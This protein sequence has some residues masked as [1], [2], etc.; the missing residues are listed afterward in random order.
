MNIG[1]VRAVSVSGMH[2]DTVT[3]QGFISSGLPYFT[4]VGLPDS[5]LV[6]AR[7]RV[8]A[9]CKAIHFSWP[10]S[11]ITVNLSPASL[12]K[13]GAGFDLSI[14]TCIFSALHCINSSLID[15]TVVMG[16]LALDGSVLPIPAILP[17]MLHARAQGFERVII[18]AANVEEASII[19]DIEIVGVHHLYE[20]LRLLGGPSEL[21]HH[22]EESASVS[23]PSAS[24]PSSENAR[25]SQT[26]SPV[27]SAELSTSESMNPFDSISLSHHDL[28]QDF[29]EIIGHADAKWAMEIAAAGGHHVL[30]QGS[31]G[32]GK[33]ML[34]H[35]LPSI[36]PDLTHDESIELACIR[37]AQG[38]PVELPLSKSVP[39]IDIHHNATLP[40]LVGGIIGGH[41]RPGAVTLAHH[42]I[43]FMDEAPEFSRSVLQALRVPLETHSITISRT[44]GLVT[45][46][47]DFQLILAQNPCPC[48]KLWGE[49]GECV[50][51]PQ[52]LRRYRQRISAPILDRI[53]MKVPLSA[54]TALKSSSSS[55][56]ASSHSPSS[57]ASHPS[58]R[59]GHTCAPPAAE[60]YSPQRDSS[61]YADSEHMREEVRLACERAQYR[62]LNCPW[63]KNAH[64]SSTWLMEMTPRKLTSEINNLLG[65]EVITMRGAHKILR[66]SWTIA[67]LWGKNQPDIDDL[68]TAQSLYLS[69]V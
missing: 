34:A 28:P 42:G 54:L 36:M 26:L 35:C 30:L 64:A 3:V 41:I 44:R 68:R 22:A 53:D 39:F 46:P 67:D 4:L 24:T 43:L 49:R 10:H 9:A 2:T 5:V 61:F 62:F 37:S 38:L 16:E 52:E 51:T 40:A 63:K 57:H 31:P 55:H 11:R 45:Y 7:E 33:S 66:L 14:A 47:A 19:D 50:C 21:V 12:H 69:E 48:G 60:A 18:P 56:S 6:Q 32:A 1:N 23:F 27:L 8:K 15:N 29:A 59:H 17:I 65:S 20:L 13:H 25:D 58:A